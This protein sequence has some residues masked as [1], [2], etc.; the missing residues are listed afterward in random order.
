M[1]GTQGAHREH[2]AGTQQ[3]HGRHTGSTQRAHS[4]HTAGTQGAHGGHTGT[5]GAWWAHGGHTRST[6]RAHGRHREHTASTQGVHGG[7]TGSTRR[8]PGRHTGSTQRVHR[9]HTGGPRAGPTPHPHT[10]GSD[11]SHCAHR[12]VGQGGAPGTG[13]L[14]WEVGAGKHWLERRGQHDRLAATGQ[15]LST[16]PLRLLGTR[17]SKWACWSRPHLLPV[18][19]DHADVAGGHWS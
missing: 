7:H 3:T 4:R 5:Q 11:V 12:P 13:P 9:G 6:R 1:V 19:R 15:A 8:A 18:G 16:L 17:K 14:L 10:E 2:T